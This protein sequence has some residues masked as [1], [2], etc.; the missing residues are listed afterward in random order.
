[1]RTPEFQNPCHEHQPSGGGHA[2]I[3][4]DLV[5]GFRKAGFLGGLN[6]VPG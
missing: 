1:V 4:Q 6:I 5:F 2:V 3:E